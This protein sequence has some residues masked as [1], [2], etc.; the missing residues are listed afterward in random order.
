MN[1]RWKVGSREGGLI[2]KGSQ[3]NWQLTAKQASSLPHLLA[4]SINQ[5]PGDEASLIPSFVPR[6]YPNMGLVHTAC[7]WH[8]LQLETHAHPFYQSFDFSPKSVKIQCML[9]QWERVGNRKVSQEKKKRRAQAG[10][11]QHYHYTNARK[12]L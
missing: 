9:E 8:V 3:G 10:F 12:Y 6:P 1:P 5:D 11:P 7:F 4:H 2:V